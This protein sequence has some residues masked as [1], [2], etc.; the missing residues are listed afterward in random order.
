MIWCV[1]T[2]AK[3][4]EIAVIRPLGAALMAISKTHGD[5]LDVMRLPVL[6]VR[7][8][9]PN[10][11]RRRWQSSLTLRNLPNKLNT[12]INKGKLPR[13]HVTIATDQTASI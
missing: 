8:T 1:D 10:S 9:L 3:I 5:Y 12:R 11:L 13:L 4:S 7:C 6:G 2:A